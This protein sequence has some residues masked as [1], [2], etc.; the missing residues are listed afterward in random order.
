M[1]LH[2]KASLILFIMAMKILKLLSLLQISGSALR[3]KPKVHICM[4]MN[5]KMTYNGIYFHF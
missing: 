1:A 4:Y 3:I 5:N 2:E